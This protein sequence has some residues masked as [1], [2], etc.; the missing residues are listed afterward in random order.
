MKFPVERARTQALVKDSLKQSDY[1]A[2]Y[3]LKSTI[4]AN[5]PDNIKDGVWLPLIKSALYL[6]QYNDVIMLGDRMIHESYD[7]IYL[8]LLAALANNDIFT[9]MSIIKRSQLLNSPD[10][11][12]YLEID[13]ANYHLLINCPKDQSKALIL[14]NLIE[15]MIK[16]T[17]GSITKEYIAIRLCD[18]IDVIYEIGYDEEIVLELANIVKV[19]FL[20]MN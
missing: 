6:H 8:M 7:A 3:K 15:G 14:C 19:L 2:I 5:Y 12:S 20:T 1:E 10:V 16:E 17:A 9:A 11:K 18:L 4:E 13:G